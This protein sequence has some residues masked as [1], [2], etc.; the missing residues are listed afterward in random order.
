MIG[1]A[2]IWS[3]MVLQQSLRIQGIDLNSLLFGENTG[4]TD[5]CCLGKVTLE[6]DA[7]D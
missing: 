7:T 6:I 2:M 1:F 3:F 5:G 4:Q